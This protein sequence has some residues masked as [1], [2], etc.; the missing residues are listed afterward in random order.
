MG[1]AMVCEIE[2]SMDN[3]GRGREAVLD[4]VTRAKII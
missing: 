1:Q 4:K 3:K 2:G